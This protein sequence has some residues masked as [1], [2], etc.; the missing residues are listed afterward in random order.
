MNPVLSFKWYM[1]ESDTLFS[2]FLKYTFSAFKYH[3]EEKLKSRFPG[4]P[5]I[6][7]IVAWLLWQALSDVRGKMWSCINISLRTWLESAGQTYAH[8][9]IWT[10]SILPPIII[11]VYP[12]YQMPAELHSTHQILPVYRIHSA[13][14][15]T[16]KSIIDGLRQKSIY[17]T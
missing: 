3:H 6:L 9:R 7:Q 1:V 5:C 16:F 17:D 14:L 2:R 4:S 10:T 15:R 12:T 8:N 13:W 11:P